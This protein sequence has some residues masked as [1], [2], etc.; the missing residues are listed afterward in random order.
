MCSNGYYSLDSILSD[1]TPTRVIIKDSLKPVIQDDVNSYRN[2]P[3]WLAASLADK[4][5]VEIK[6]KCLTKRTLYLDLHFLPLSVITF[7]L[8]IKS[9]ALRM[10]WTSEA[11]APSFTLLESRMPNWRKTR[12]FARHGSC[13]H[14]QEDH[15]NYRAFSDRFGTIFR[16]SMSNHSSDVSE[17]MNTLTKYFSECWLNPSSAEQEIFRE[18]VRSITRYLAWKNIYFFVFLKDTNRTMTKTHS[19]HSKRKTIKVY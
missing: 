5:L 7:F 17:Y 9:G 14:G 1:E 16:E 3:L 4:E 2:M 12:V 19:T 6:P 8:G 13:M 10:Q 11:N 18:G 15:E